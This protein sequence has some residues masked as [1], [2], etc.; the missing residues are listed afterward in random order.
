MRLLCSNVLL[1]I[2][3]CPSLSIW[4][5]RGHATLWVSKAKSPFAQRCAS[6]SQYRSGHPRLH[7][8][9][10]TLPSPASKPSAERLIPAA[11]AIDA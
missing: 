11:T 2:G 8:I 6:S 9:Y 3:A 10:G 1:V 5:I 7:H 4:A